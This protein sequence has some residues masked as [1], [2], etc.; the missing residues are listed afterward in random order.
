MRNGA[1][2]LETLPVVKSIH[3][4]ILAYSNRIISD[5]QKEKV[6]RDVAVVM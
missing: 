4:G 2:D 3:V 6:I 5:L 1:I